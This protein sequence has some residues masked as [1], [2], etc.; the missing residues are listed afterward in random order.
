MNYQTI[1]EKL[2]CPF[3]KAEL[4][5][6]VITLKEETEE[7]LEGILSCATCKRVY[8]IV[9]GIPIMVPDEFREER[10]ERPLFEKWEQV[11]KRNLGEGSVQI[12]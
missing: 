2:C 5:V 11:Q 6:Q 9:N 10:F 12:P 7:V 3:G 1:K 4:A 8:P